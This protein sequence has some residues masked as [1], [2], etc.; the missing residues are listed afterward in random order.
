[1]SF[2]RAPTAVVAAMLA[3]ACAVLLLALT[4][5]TTG[6]ASRIETPDIVRATLSAPDMPALALT[7]DRARASADKPLFH[8]DR[9]PHG[10]GLTAD[11]EADGSGETEAPFIL[12]GVVLANGMA[13]ASLMR[14]VE[15]DIQWVNRG[16]AIDGWTLVSVRSDRVELTRGEF[17]TTLLLYP[18]R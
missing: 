16:K 4:L 9:K 10:S 18:E 6:S 7:S 14:T 17:R 2:V 12:K 8:P 13:R 1:M 3:G 11:G 15:G 5:L